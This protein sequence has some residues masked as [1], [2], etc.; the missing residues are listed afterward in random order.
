MALPEALQQL[1]CSQGGVFTRRQALAGGLTRGEVAGL[2]QRDCVLVRRGVHTDAASWQ[3]TTDDPRARLLLRAAAELVVVADGYLD[4]RTAAVALGLPLLGPLPRAPEI[5]RPPRS[6][7]DRASVAGV[8]V[9][10]VPEE[11]RTVVN[12]LRVLGL[13]RTAA[14]LARTRPLREA[15]VVLDA[16]A[17]ADPAR[18][19]WALAHSAVAL[20]D[21]HGVVRVEVDGRVWD[22]AEPDAGWVDAVSGAIDADGSATGGT[23]PG[24]GL[25]RLSTG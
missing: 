21:R 18:T 20:A 13:A 9:A 22:R 16:G 23:S 12:G 5:V 1:A 17:A 2:L 14:D 4:R 6:D 3:A 10:A 7:G 25:V 19:A 15:V 8:R 24:D 11:H